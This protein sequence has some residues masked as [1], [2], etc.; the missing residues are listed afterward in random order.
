M[1]SVASMDTANDILIGADAIAGFMGLSRRQI[2]HATEYGHLPTFRI[3]SVICARR[4]T[5]WRWMDECE[6]AALKRRG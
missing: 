5:L 1:D 2:Y 6:K 4:T 3:G